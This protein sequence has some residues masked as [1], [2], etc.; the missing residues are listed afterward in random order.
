MKKCV[1]VLLLL[2]LTV[3]TFCPAPTVSAADETITMMSYNICASYVSGESPKDNSLFISSRYQQVFQRIN[4]ANPDIISLVEVNDSWRTYLNQTYLSGNTYDSFGYS[5]R[6]NRLA[7]ASGQWDL[8]NFIMY[9]K[10]KYILM[11]KGR[12]WCSA[13]P[14]QSNSYT[15]PDGTVGDFGRCINWVK[16]E[17]Y[18]SGRQFYVVSVHID[19]KNESVRNYSTTLISQRMNGIAGG[20]PV[21]VM[22]DFNCNSSK[23]AY[24]NMTSNGYADAKS[25]ASSTNSL[26]TF[27]NWDKSRDMTSIKPIDHCFLTKN[28]FSVS[29]YRVDSTLM[30]NG[31][32]P[33]DH[34]PIVVKATFLTPAVSRDRMEL[35]AGS[36]YSKDNQ[37]NYITGIK[38]K[39]TKATFMNNFT[40]GSILELNT[41]GLYVGSGC[42][43]TYGNRA[44]TLIVKGDL[45]S[46]GTVTSTDLLRIKQFF[47]LED[48]SDWQKAAADVTGDGTVTSAD[49]IRVKLHFNGALNLYA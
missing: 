26:G 8:L 32:A 38:A 16:L 37:N 41:N 40:Y 22:G 15:L 17:S 36:V 23:T 33:S 20:L 46:N 9:R 6:G 2:C 18:E 47:G 1:F 3:S 7:G 24:K 44:Y 30:S 28:K 10:D 5:S 13:T 12:F 34:Y 31:Y 29:S 25:I 4:A 14:E 48:F 43:L 11:D 42:Q 27:N 49:Y 39:T 19:A 45:D 21:I 35:I